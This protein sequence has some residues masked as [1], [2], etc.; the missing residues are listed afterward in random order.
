MRLTV[1]FTK[2]LHP[3]IWMFFLYFCL[4]GPGPTN[5]LGAGQLHDFQSLIENN[6]ALIVSD[7]LGTAIFAKNADKKLMP[8]ST[9]KIFTAMVA[10]HY[11]GLDY[12]FTTEFYL[13]QNK[14]LKIKGH[15]D[16]FLIS[17]VVAEIA[18]NL[19]T[20]LKRVND[21]V[22][23]DSYFSEPLTIPG[24]SSSSEPY[25]APNGALCVNFNTV[26]FKKVNGTYISAEPQT[27]LLPFALK[28]I[29]TANSTAGRIVFS[30]D[31]D[32]CTLYAG[33]LFRY[34]LKKKGIQTGSRIRLGRIRKKKDSLIYTYV[35]RFSLEDIIAGLLEHSNNYTTN[36]LL[37]AAGI[38]AYGPP[39]TLSKGVQAA[40][41][42]AADRL[43]LNNF[44]I[45]EGSGI[46]RENKV[47]AGQLH[48]I[49]GVF[50]PY[51]YLLRQEGNEFYKTGTLRGISSRVGY[52]ENPDGSFYRY[53]VIINTPGKST[54]P[55]MKKL[56]R[57]VEM[58][59][60]SPE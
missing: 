55:I 26:N 45:A 3:L 35:S 51:R 9:L 59:V 52:I 22:L 33:H 4:F 8:A 5:T 19:S 36:Q 47:T 24:I 17:E 38:Q 16:P 57:I 30:H 12:K 56:R 23:D 39:G 60:M 31:A 11:L 50:A 6:D 13:D 27:P 25:D 54:G 40:K 15:G 28:R 48:K 2:G 18:T 32:M 37:I 10:L 41:A 29:K 53:V 20:R 58:S 21:I 42:Y 43:Q 34:F 49:L 14:N 44:N 7:P 1:I 46:S